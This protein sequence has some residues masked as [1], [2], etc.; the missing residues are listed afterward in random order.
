MA[1]CPSMGVSNPSDFTGSEIRDVPSAFSNKTKQ[2]ARTPQ[3]AN[4]MSFISNCTNVDLPVSDSVG[5][6]LPQQ[7]SL[8]LAHSAPAHVQVQTHA[9]AHEHAHAHTHAHTHAHI[10]EH[11]HEHTHKHTHAHTQ[12]KTTIGGRTLKI[13]TLGL[14]IWNCM[15]RQ[16]RTQ[17]LRITKS[18][19]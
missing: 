12:E 7:E 13:H 19:S 17:I 14:T 2:D 3:R 15:Q 5:V 1:I 6:Q 11:T 8:R 10:H 9:Q 4:I 18:Q 16:R